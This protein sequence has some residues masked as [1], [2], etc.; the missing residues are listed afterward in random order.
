MF[1]NI[2]VASTNF[3]WPVP[4]FRGQYQLSI[5]KTILTYA[6]FECWHCWSWI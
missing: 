3:Q 5:A 6:Y 2:S 4:T 1:L